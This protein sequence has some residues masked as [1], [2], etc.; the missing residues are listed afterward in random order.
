M[1]DENWFKADF[2]ISKQVTNYRSF[3]AIWNIFD[4]HNKTVIGGDL[5]KTAT[6]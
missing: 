3:I 4:S 6:F 2:P 5:S 1:L